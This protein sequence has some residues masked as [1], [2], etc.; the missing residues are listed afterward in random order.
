MRQ[1]GKGRYNMRIIQLSKVKTHS[2]EVLA[3]FVDTILLHRA[4]QGEHFPKELYQQI[5]RLPSRFYILRRMSSAEHGVL[6]ENIQDI[7]KKVTGTALP[8]D[9]EVK[10]AP[11]AVDLDGNFWMIPGG[12][13]LKGFNH[14]A[15]AKR[16][17]ALLCSLL[18]INPYIFEQK[19]HSDPKGLIRLIINQGGVRLNI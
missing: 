6:F 8:D 7:W 17:K 3:S 14:Y 9:H 13:L 1:S 2:P 18:D 11:S 12:M 19:L 15:T 4:G 16:H 5:D 10:P